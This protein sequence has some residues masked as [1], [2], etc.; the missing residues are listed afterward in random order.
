MS[1]LSERFYIMEQKQKYKER[2]QEQRKKEI[3]K[4]Q[5]KKEQ[6]AEQ[7]QYEKDL[8]LACKRD[9]KEKFEEEFRLQ[10]LKAKYHF[11][12]IENRD[13]L[14]KSI[15]KSEIEGDYLETNYN[16]I[17]NE[18][19]KKYE[20]NEQYKTEKEKEIAQE[21]VEKMQ[22]TWEKEQKKQEVKNV[23]TNI[24]SVIL[25]IF[26]HPFIFLSLIIIGILI[27][28]FMGALE[29]GFFKAFGISIII[30]IVLI[31]LLFGFIK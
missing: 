20:L 30:F 31:G 10:G 5:R 3:K 17:L 19:I 11:Y 9:L 7:K 27:W 29:L 6:Q 14:I 21:Y 16:K 23:V 2:E 28:V 26:E 13:I 25:K 12:K 15:A 18:I 1:E 8:L 4:I 22:P 24:L